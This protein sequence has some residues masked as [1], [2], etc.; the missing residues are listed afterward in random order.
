M[1]WRAEGRHRPRLTAPG[2]PPAPYPGA[3]PAPGPMPVRA[4]LVALALSAAAAAQAP[5][6]SRITYNVAVADVAAAEHFYADVLGL[7]RVEGDALG[8]PSGWGGPVARTVA[9]RGDGVWLVLHL[10]P[11]HGTCPPAAR[12]EGPAFALPVPV[13][14]LEPVLLRLK[15]EGLEVSGPIDRSGR[16]RVR[17]RAPVGPVVEL[18]AP[19][20]D[21]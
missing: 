13:P 1:T 3:P 21:G 10:V 17:V 12:R 2:P 6:T 19:L 9:A 16:R 18:R 7:K 11:C 8:A 5:P 4:A 15:A 14:R 20:G